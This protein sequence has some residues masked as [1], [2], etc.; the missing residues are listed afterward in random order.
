MSAAREGAEGARE[1]A[2]DILAE[3]L[4]KTEEALNAAEELSKIEI[5]AAKEEAAAKIAAKDAE[6]A[7]AV[8]EVER[9]MEEE[10]AAAQAIDL[11]APLTTSPTLVTIHTAIRARVPTLTVDRSPAPDITALT[12]L[13]T[14]GELE[15]AC[16]SQL[17]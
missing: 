11:L 4:A 10:V 15:R 5:A 2:E 12:D 17:A 14:S 8:A 9:R 6:M 13:I 7:K 16:P 1:S 3:E